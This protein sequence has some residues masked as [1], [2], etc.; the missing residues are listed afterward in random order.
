MNA[1]TDTTTAQAPTN[2]PAPVQHLLLAEISP[3][4]TRKTL[5]HIT[6]DQIELRANTITVVLREIMADHGENR[7]FG[8]NE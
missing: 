2:L 1:S 4:A 3:N 8:I 7:D 6:T 5:G